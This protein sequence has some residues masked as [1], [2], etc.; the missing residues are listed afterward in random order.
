M[1]GTSRGKSMQT[2][3][4]D[5]KGNEDI[6]YRGVRKRTWGKFAAEIRDPTKPGGRSWLGTFDTPEEAA[7]AYDRAAFNIKGHLAMLNFPNEYYS[8]LPNPP[9][10][11][12]SA[13]RGT[14]HQQS[15]SST[16]SS[17]M[18]Q[19][20]KEV[21]EFEYLDDSVLDDLLQSEELRRNTQF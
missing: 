7:R 16:P 2:K 5:N 10:P 12:Y 6:H 14:H 21:I 15:M 4:H 17:V 11:S 1:E 3:D 8:R 19:D 9:Y 18:R 20:N 13:T